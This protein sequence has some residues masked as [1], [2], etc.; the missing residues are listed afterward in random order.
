MDINTA[1]TGAHIT[2][3]FTHLIRNM[4]RSINAMLGHDA[5]NPYKNTWFTIGAVASWV[6]RRFTENIEKTPPKTL[7]F[8]HNQKSRCASA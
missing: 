3:G 5:G 2:G 4:W 1:S 7:K 8:S 6:K